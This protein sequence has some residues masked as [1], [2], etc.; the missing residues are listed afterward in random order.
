[1]VALVARA[2]ELEVGRGRIHDGS[3]PL[4]ALRALQAMRQT[5]AEIVA[6]VAAPGTPP[7]NGG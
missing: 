1:M 3:V 6:A 4:R 7:Q 2:Q 5:R